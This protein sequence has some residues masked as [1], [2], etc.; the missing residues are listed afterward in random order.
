[1]SV[2]KCCCTPPPK[3]PPLGS[4][5]FINNINGV[6]S[7][8]CVDNVD[9]IFCSTKTNS[10]F[11]ENSTCGIKIA[12]PVP[13]N[14]D[15]LD[16]YIV[17]DHFVPFSYDF[18]ARAGDYFL[19]NLSNGTTP[20]DIK[21]H[22][23]LYIGNQP[24]ITTREIP[25][26]DYKS[27]SIYNGISQPPGTINNSQWGSNYYLLGLDKDNKLIYTTTTIGISPIEEDFLKVAVQKTA[28]F[29]YK[30]QTDFTDNGIPMSYVD[31]R[32]DTNASYSKAEA[33]Y[34]KLSFVYSNLDEF[35]RSGRIYQKGH[36]RLGAAVKAEDKIYQ[37][38]FRGFLGEEK[39][40]NPT[41][42]TFQYNISSDIMDRDSRFFDGALRQF[43]SFY[44]HDRAEARYN[45]VTALRNVIDL[46]AAPLTSCALTSDGNVTSWGNA[47]DGGDDLLTV[48]EQ[49]IQEWNA[50]S[51]ATRGI[52]TQNSRNCLGEN[53]EISGDCVKIE[54]F[55]CAFL[56]WRQNNKLSIIFGSTF[57][58]HTLVKESDNVFGA[59]NNVIERVKTK[60][61]SWQN[62]D[63]E[64][65]NN[66]TI[67]LPDGSCVI[68]ESKNITQSGR[69]YHVLK[70]DC[71]TFGYGDETQWGNNLILGEFEAPSDYV[72][73]KKIVP[74]SLYIE[75]AYSNTSGSRKKST[76][77]Y[78]VLWDNGQLD[79]MIFEKPLTTRPLPLSNGRYFN[80]LAGL[81]STSEGVSSSRSWNNVKDI[82]EVSSFF[83]WGFIGDENYP[84]SDHNCVLFLNDGRETGS[85]GVEDNVI[86]DLRNDNCV[87]TDVTK[88]DAD[89]YSYYQVKLS[90]VSHVDQVTSEFN[91]SQDPQPD[92]QTRS[93]S[94]CI[95]HTKNKCVEK[96]ADYEYS[97]FKISSYVS[98]RGEFKRISL[99]GSSMINN[100]RVNIFR[101]KG[102]IFDYSEREISTD[103]NFGSAPS[104]FTTEGCEDLCIDCFFPFR[105][106]NMQDGSC[107]DC[108]DGNQNLICDFLDIYPISH[109]LG[110][111]ANDPCPPPDT[112]GCCCKTF[113]TGTPNSISVQDP[114]LDD[115]DCAA[116]GETIYTPQGD[117][118]SD[119]EVSFSF[120]P[121]DDTFTID[122][123][124]N[125]AVTPFC[126]NPDNP[127]PSDGLSYR[128]TNVEYSEYNGPNVNGTR[129]RFTIEKLNPNVTGRISIRGCSYSKLT[130]ENVNNIGT[131]SVPPDDSWTTY[132]FDVI[133]SSISYSQISNLDFT[134]VAGKDIAE[135]DQQLPSCATSINEPQ[136]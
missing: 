69:K 23:F 28:P 89:N 133:D 93:T 106:C 107:V 75:N 50:N 26:K 77:A 96:Q 128:I 17:E 60:L 91:N 62:G 27:I 79:Y 113:F 82:F 10:I 95:I 51:R 102:R 58:R 120:K 11:N 14:P 47:L 56:V 1:M 125:A 80:R 55:G 94:Y 111:C 4:C 117:P 130:G 122:D 53:L 97:M 29:S 132:S 121:F 110:S 114:V 105:K 59:V 31:Q 5:C 18:G 34:G 129:F 103:S 41:N 124:L 65:D 13:S 3:G 118:I 86:T 40:V 90:N 12:C 108:F 24:R 54:K 39:N 115:S 37:I 83:G 66:A 84:H 126:S 7:P 87:V 112:P 116:K 19:D 101:S 52:Y 73:I 43:Y 70:S 35:N 15:T 20:K 99:P 135:L 131:S 45:R 92:I 64:F 68:K 63:V 33:N 8:D 88:F 67:I 25:L 38:A 30:P 46:K 109:A 74:L 36:Y 119:S 98:T 104:I 72:R 78:L 85:T 2:N 76:P 48:H 61:T 6:V 22:D 42:L 9:E 123:C 81:Y 32:I 100:R 49:Q 16:R 21:I 57:V 44:S 127:T 134:W 136:P 71:R